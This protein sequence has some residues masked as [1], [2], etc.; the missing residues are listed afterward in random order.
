MTSGGQPAGAFSQLTRRAM[1]RPLLGVAVFLGTF[2]VAA[3]PTAYAV[4]GTDLTKHYPVVRVLLFVAWLMF[5]FLVGAVAVFE[6]RLLQEGLATLTAQRR[7]QIARRRRDAVARAV[8]ALLTPGVAGLPEEF[9]FHAFVPNSGVLTPVFEDQPDP[10]ERWLP[11]Q[12]AVG[13]AWA[14]PDTESPLLFDTPEKLALLNDGLTPEQREAYGHLR[15]VATVLI[16]DE[17]NRPIGVASVDR[18]TDSSVD[19]ATLIDQLLLFSG[20]LGVLLADVI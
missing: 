11:N 13:T 2:Y 12:G 7:A 9:S 16:R 10:W 15:V 14:N 6:N 8:R 5:A 1:E 19:P 17:L 18:A 20:T 3:L 4:F